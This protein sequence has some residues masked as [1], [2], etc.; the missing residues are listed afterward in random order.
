MAELLARRTATER[1]AENPDG[2]ITATLSDGPIHYQDGQGAWQVIDPG[3]TDSGTAFTAH[4]NA[5]SVSI[6]KTASSGITFSRGAASLTLIPVEVDL[7]NLA[8]KARSKI[9]NANAAATVLLYDADTVRIA[10]LYGG[11]DFYYG[12]SGVGLKELIRIPS[13][14]TLP[15]PTS[16]GWL[17]ADTWLVWVSRMTWSGV[18]PQVNGVPIANGAEDEDTPTTFVDASQVVQFLFQPGWAYSANSRRIRVRRRY[19]RVS[20]QWYVLYG[21]P[22]DSVQRAAYPVTIDPTTTLNSDTGDGHIIYIDGAYSSVN[23]NGTTF[24]PGQVDNGKGS[25]AW[26]RAFLKFA[27][28]GWA[29]RTV[30]IATFGLYGGTKVGTPTIVLDE[31]PDFGTLDS[32]DW[33]ATPNATI[34]SNF[35][36]TASQYNTADTKDR[37]VVAKSGSWIAY[38]LKKDT[39]PAVA[40]DHYCP[41][42]SADNA[43]NKP[44]LDLTYYEA[45]TQN[46][47]TPGDTQVALSWAASGG[48]V[49]GDHQHVYYI[50]DAGAEPAFPAGWTLFGTEPA[51][52]ATTQ[53]V[54]GLT[55]G[56][57][58]WFKIVD[59]QVV[60]ATSYEGSRSTG[61][62]ATPAGG[63][64]GGSAP[65]RRALT[66]WGT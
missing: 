15:D 4:P 22:Y 44:K 58:Y 24:T 49:A 45:H 47:P 36:T 50:Q 62:S 61:Q 35:G 6:S 26:Q 54:T 43:S 56:L 34:T 55:N 31:I 33:G 23:T 21:I 17:P 10:N 39:E 30:S 25:Y 16:L 41:Y 11:A 27:L 53:T 64:G 52:N 65:S 37:F 20:G 59:V 14:P 2:S 9:A 7:L 42:N 51:W 66:G 18:T 46:A 32:T 12:D 63:G 48:L 3:W 60:G 1:H 19:V 38:R 28:S 8:T 29:T 5:Y 57:Q 13:L 40:A